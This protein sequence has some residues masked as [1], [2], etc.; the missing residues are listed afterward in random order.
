M[1]AKKLF[2][3]GW[4]FLF[5]MNAVAF[6]GE[7]TT[8]FKNPGNYA[9]G[10][11]FDGESLWIADRQ[12]DVLY[13]I[14]PEN[15]KIIGSIS[16]PGYWPMGLTWDGTHLWNADIKGGIPESENYDG[17]IYKIDPKDGTIVHTVNAPTKRPRG[18]AYDGEYFWCVDGANDE[19]VQFDANDGT[20]IRS[21]PAPSVD[22][23][24]ITFD[25][26]YL[27]VSDRTRDEIYMVNPE[28]GAVIIIADAPGKFT[29]GLAWDGSSLWAT[30]SQEDRVFKLKGNDGEKYIKSNMRK[31][32]VDYTYKITNYGPGKVK[33]ADIHLAIPTDR[34]TQE[35][36]SDIKYNPDYTDIVTDQWNQSTA[37]YRIKD[38]EANESETIHMITTVKIWDIRYFIYPDQVGSLEKMPEDVVNL[39][40]KNNKKYQLH[41]PVIR[42]AVK[43]AVGD[44]ENPYWIM[45]NIFNYVIDNMYYE[46]EGG[47]NTAPA[48]LDRG[49]GSCSEYS[50]VFI[51]MCRS[52]GIPARYVGSAVVRGDDASMD[53]VFHRWVEVYLP[54]YGWVMVDPS[55]G[56]NKDP[57]DQARY[58]GSLSNRFLITTQSGGGS[59]TMGWTYNSNESMVTEPKTHVV[60]DYYADWEPIE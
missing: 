26:K 10:M 8:S 22:P 23:R 19:I 44:E 52:A 1:T 35:I 54:N 59:K 55:G 30:D 6:T 32:K 51:S 38:L 40:L 28:D 2:T 57:R 24:G 49:N 7:V 46:M 36:T 13:K 21:I 37:H 41:H 9:T 33:Q 20:T 47:W 58:I 42:D 14:N 34:V 15:G 11:T 4:L 53:D 56:D 17:K 18:L 25:G 5:A 39:Y 45:R 48:V 29:R 50:F 43:K 31:A 12:E 16:S 27:W 3:L 60:V